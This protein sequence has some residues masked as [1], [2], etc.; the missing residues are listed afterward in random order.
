MNRYIL[1]NVYIYIYHYISIYIHTLHIILYLF[2]LQYMWQVFFVNSA[3]GCNFVAG[4]CTGVPGPK[5]SSRRIAPRIKALT[6]SNG[7][8]TTSNNVCK[9]DL[10]HTKVYFGFINQIGK[11]NKKRVDRLA[12]FWCRMMCWQRSAFPVSP[13]LPQWFPTKTVKD[14]LFG[15]YPCLEMS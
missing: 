8:L 9:M 5:P 15:G 1:V 4:C 10:T 2:S 14:W 6:N 12:H 11:P 13:R 3:W 7:L